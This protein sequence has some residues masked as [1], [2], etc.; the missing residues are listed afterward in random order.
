M[1]NGLV[2]LNKD[3]KNSKVF[4]DWGKQFSI[5]FEI[6]ITKEFTSPTWLNVFHMTIESKISIDLM[7]VKIREINMIL[8]SMFIYRFFRYR[9]TNG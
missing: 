9:N 6:E 1:L 3:S 8:K 7:L 2:A 4:R 5:K